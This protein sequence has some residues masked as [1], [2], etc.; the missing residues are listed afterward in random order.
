MASKKAPYVYVAQ[1][2]TRV[3][4]DDECYASYVEKF[5][6]GI[7]P[8]HPVSALEGG[9]AWMLHWQIYTAYQAGWEAKANN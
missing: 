2:P 6:G 9:M 5:C 4:G 1:K 8:P 7:V 3:E